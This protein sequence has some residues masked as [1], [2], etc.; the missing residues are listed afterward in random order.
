MQPIYIPTNNAGD[1][2]FSTLSP[3]F[4]LFLD[5]LMMAI[6]TGVKW[7]FTVVLICISLIIRHTEHFS[8]VYWPSVCLLWI[9]VYLGLLLII[10]L[11]CL[12]FCYWVIW[13][14]CIFWKWSLCC[15]VYKHVL[16]FYM[17]FFSFCLWFPLLCTSLYVWLGPFVYF[18]FYVYWLERLIATTYVREYFAYFFSRGFTVS[19]LIF[20]SLKRHSLIISPIA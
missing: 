10:W 12:L 15:I 7:H 11:G 18:C 4:L 9:N 13:T 20:K 3:S 2:L 5:F 1:S 8:C 17:P 6:L 14:I 16:P 19:W